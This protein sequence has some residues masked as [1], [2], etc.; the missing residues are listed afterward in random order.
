MREV[1]SPG[2]LLEFCRLPN[3][4]RWTPSRLS[5]DSETGTYT[6]SDRDLFDV[7][8]SD[9]DRF[10][11][12]WARYEVHRQAEYHPY[13]AV[14]GLPL[15]ATT[16]PVANQTG[17]LWQYAVQQDAMPSSPP[18]SADAATTVSS[19]GTPGWIGYPLPALSPMNRVTDPPRLQLTS[20]L[21]MTFQVG[22][23]DWRV[24]AT[25]LADAAV[26]GS[27]AVAFELGKGV[28]KGVAIMG[29][30]ES[31]DLQ[32]T[33]PELLAYK[34]ALSD[35]QSVP[36]PTRLTERLSAARLLFHNVSSPDW[37]PSLKVTVEREPMKGTAATFSAVQPIRL[38]RHTGRAILHPVSPSG[39]NVLVVP[40][41]SQKPPESYPDASRGYV[42]EFSRKKACGV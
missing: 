17:M 24:I 27:L 3:Q 23:C 31:L 11:L 25:P 5:I 28:V 15:T 29:K 40:D 32:L 18:A 34:E 35:P 26:Q 8:E 7:A 42:E 37:R 6:S 22:G 14:Q 2:I 1:L 19:P 39:R 9:G 4:P 21:D 30:D 10:T 20:E 12:G 41:Q 16:L 38:F 13:F 36:A 33:T